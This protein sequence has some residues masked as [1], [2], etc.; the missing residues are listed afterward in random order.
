MIYRR[1]ALLFVGGLGK[2]ILITNMPQ[3]QDGVL[4]I[5]GVI[6]KIELSERESR[7]GRG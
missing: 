1:T 7:V 3:K 5:L 4:S 2:K 6:N